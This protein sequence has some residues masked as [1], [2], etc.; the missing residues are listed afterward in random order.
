MS[1]AEKWSDTF[2]GN[3]DQVANDTAVD[4]NAPRAALRI[5]SRR[6]R[7]SGA[8]EGESFHEQ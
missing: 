8:K 6:I 4:T 7:K 2:N 3:D 1:L 5:E